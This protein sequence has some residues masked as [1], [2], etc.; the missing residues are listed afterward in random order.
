[1][2]AFHKF[3]CIY[4]RVNIDDQFVQMDFNSLNNNKYI[5]SVQRG[6]AVPSPAITWKWREGCDA[7][8]LTLPRIALGWMR[9]MVFGGEEAVRSAGARIWTARGILLDSRAQRIP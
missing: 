7:S 6:W 3:W 1:M 8:P 2:T 9:T 5:I 4:A